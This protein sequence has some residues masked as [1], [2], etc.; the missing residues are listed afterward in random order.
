MAQTGD[1]DQM[2]VDTLHMF[3]QQ[4]KNLIHEKLL[5]HGLEMLEMPTK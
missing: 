1:T 5:S 2:S 4:M 3:L